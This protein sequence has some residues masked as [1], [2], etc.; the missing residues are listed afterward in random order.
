VSENGYVGIYMAVSVVCAL[1]LAWD[2]CRMRGAAFKEAGHRKSVW[3]L[4]W[5]IST[6]VLLSPFVLIWYL[7]RVRPDVRQADMDH[8][9]A[10]YRRKMARRRAAYTRQQSAPTPSR[11]SSSSFS[12]TF[13]RKPQTCSRCGGSGTVPCGPCQ[14]RGY[15]TS[16]TPRANDPYFNEESCMNCGRTGKLRCGSCNGTGK[17]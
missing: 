4:I 12:P 10:R 16:S 5:L 1:F 11:T 7:I 13:E 9:A 8:I 17:V 3:L 6:G 2:I 14:G 15:Q